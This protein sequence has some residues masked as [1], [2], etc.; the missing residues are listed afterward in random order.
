MPQTVQIE[1]LDKQHPDVKIFETVWE[2]LELLMEGG[3]R[4]QTAVDRFL[5]K[6]T[7]ELLDAYMERAR[8]LSYTP[9]IGTCIGWYQSFLFRR[10]PEVEIPVKDPFYDAFKEDADRKGTSYVDVWRTALEHLLLYGRTWVQI[11][12]PKPDVEPQSLLDE[13][14]MGLDQPY[15]FVHNPRQ[16]VNWGED[17]LGNLNWVLT[18]H[19]ETPNDF[20]SDAKPKF[21]WTLYDRQGYQRYEAEAQEATGWMTGIQYLQSADQTTAVLTDQGKHPL[22]Q[23]NI[24]P[25]R[26]IKLDASLW[27]ANRCFLQALDY[28][29]AENAFAYSLFMSCLAIPILYTDDPNPV[30]Q[31]SESAHIKLKKD[32]KFGFA[33]PEGKSYEATGNRLESLRQEIFRAFYLQAQGR[34]SSATSMMS[35]GYSKELDMM[36]ANDIAT[37]LGDKLRVE[38]K[39]V[40]KMV[41]LAHGDED[42]DDLAGIQVRGFRFETKPATEAAALTEEIS[43]AYLAMN[44]PGIPDT[45]RKQM[46]LMI[47]R[48]ALEDSGPDI[49]AKVEAEIKAMPKPEDVQANQTDQAFGQAF[50]KMNDRLAA[51][52]ELDDTGAEGM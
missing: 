39:N 5:Y 22:S 29:N 30:F 32:D 41:M 48:N 8:R 49:L 28:F 35:S 4:L 16:I 11:D 52:T 50:Q 42:R 19:V 27:M 14:T 51:R 26:Q 1:K 10:A 24:V 6:R 23:Y 3:I 21:V 43:A 40:L 44:Q 38:M 20:L 25:F 2:N 13:Q 31:I 15:V 37:A 36:P 9:L 33:E 18:K 45:L 17:S 7:F 12:A 46:L 47:A 34:S